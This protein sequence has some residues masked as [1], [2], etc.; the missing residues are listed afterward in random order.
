MSSEL[1]LEQEIEDLKSENASLK[2]ALDEAREQLK[3]AEKD[4][5]DKFGN[6]ID[7]ARA[8]NALNQMT[9]TRRDWYICAVVASG[10]TKDSDARDYVRDAERLMAA[11]DKGGR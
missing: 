3:W 10:V 11:A 2:K 1:E 6:A 8:R 5:A 7:L 4:L 9:M